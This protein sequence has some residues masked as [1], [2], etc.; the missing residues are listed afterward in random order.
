MPDHLW[1]KKEKAVRLFSLI[2]CLRWYSGL[3]RESNNPHR[4]ELNPVYYFLP[5]WRG[6]TWII[7]GCS[8]N[9]LLRLEHKNHCSFQ[10]VFSWVSCSGGNELPCGKDTQVAFGEV[11]GWDTGLQLTASTHP[12]IKWG[13]SCPGSGSSSS[14]SPYLDG[15]VMTKPKPEPSSCAAPK[16]LAHRNCEVRPTVLSHHVWGYPVPQILI[17]NTGS[18][19]IPHQLPEAGVVQSFQYLHLLLGL[20]HSCLQIFCDTS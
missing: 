8:R 10:M 15:N 1:E 2:L 20:Y 5:H 16:L 7:I 18:M 19:R 13:A 3:P 14:L 6:L 11:Q 4:L 12:P 17:T 9:D